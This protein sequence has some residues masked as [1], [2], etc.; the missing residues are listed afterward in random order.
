MGKNYTIIR[1]KSTEVENA[2][3]IRYSLNSRRQAWAVIISLLMLVPYMVK[4][5]PK[6]GG[7]CGAHTSFLLAGDSLMISHQ[8]L[9]GATNYSLKLRSSAGGQWIEPVGDVASG[10]SKINYFVIYL[11][12]KPNDC[13]KT[14]LRPGGYF[15][16][17]IAYNEVIG[18]SCE[19][20]GNFY[21]TD[22]QVWKSTYSSWDVVNTE[23]APVLKNK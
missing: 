9:T 1:E 19:M 6:G 7:G 16:K 17:V 23:Y 15:F 22:E 2:G 12:N 10:C 4:S 8:L 18:D 21:L 3:Q 14:A 5:Q 20:N 11:R 13:Q